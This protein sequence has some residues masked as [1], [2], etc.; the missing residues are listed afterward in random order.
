MWVPSVF[1]V[2]SRSVFF[3]GYILIS[4]GFRTEGMKS[5]MNSMTPCLFLKCAWYLLTLYTHL[6]F[7]SSR[8]SEYSEPNSSKEIWI[9]LSVYRFFMRNK[10]VQPFFELGAWV[11]PFFSTC[12]PRF[13]PSFTICKKFECDNLVERALHY[14]FTCLLTRSYKFL[15]SEKENSAS[16]FFRTFLLIGVF[17]CTSENIC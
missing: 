14:F 15:N 9:C 12:F 10:K 4:F 3:S 17:A 7:F 2:L 5:S 6:G 13:P 16:S 8:R 11:F 1:L